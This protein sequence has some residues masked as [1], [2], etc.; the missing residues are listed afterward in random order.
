MAILLIRMVFK[1]V[2][3]KTLSCREAGFDCDHVVKGETEEEVMKNGG[4]HAMKVHGMKQ[5]E[6]TP[7]MKQKLKGL[8]RSS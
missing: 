4:E 7:E 1:Y 2:I 8:I 5:E 6:I 3:M